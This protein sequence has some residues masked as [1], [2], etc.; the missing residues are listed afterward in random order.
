M[1]ALIKAVGFR[2]LPLVISFILVLAQGLPA[3]SSSGLTLKVSSPQGEKGAQAKVEITAERA[4]GTE[5]GQFTLYFDPAIARPV[6]LEPGSLVTEA[7]NSLH[8][9][10]LEYA[11]GALM[12]MWVTPAADTR[13][14][15]TVCSIVFDLIG[16]GVTELTLAEIVIAPQEAK[17]GTAVSGKL[18]V[19]STQAQQGSSGSGSLTPEGSE[20]G[21]SQGTITGENAGD[22]LAPPAANN[23]ALQLNG[24]HKNIKGYVLPAA[25]IA[26]ILAVGLVVRIRGKAKKAK[27]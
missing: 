3:L 7:A 1:K 15:G 26:F 17:V 16:E 14:S 5:G 6:L 27:H 9:A 10:N 4:T 21:V 12:F 20:E 25:I 19:D 2:L 22:K 13:A 11:A 8:M 18:N 23:G 24:G